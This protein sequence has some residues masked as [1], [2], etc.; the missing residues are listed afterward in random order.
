MAWGQGQ[1]KREEAPQ[2][3]VL[4]VRTEMAIPKARGGNTR[5]AGGGEE[6]GTVTEEAR[7]E[8]TT[9]DGD[10]VGMMGET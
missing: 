9:R 10:S 4:E 6:S 5:G 2:E 1:Q 8:R 3:R 7:S